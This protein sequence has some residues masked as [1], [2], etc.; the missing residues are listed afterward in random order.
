M[1]EERKRRIIL[2][3]NTGAGIQ[4][5]AFR[6]CPI[7]FPERHAPRLCQGIHRPRSIAAVGK[8]CGAEIIRQVL[9]R[10]LRITV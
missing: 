5:A 7:G 3:G 8:N 1:A 6:V 9:C 10:M 2:I 4:H